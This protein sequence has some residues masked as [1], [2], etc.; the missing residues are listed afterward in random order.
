MNVKTKIDL[1]NEI[2][3]VV[4]MMSLTGKC[5]IAGSLSLKNMLYPND[6]DGLE[7][8]KRDKHML[9][10]FQ[11]VI[12]NL[13]NNNNLFIGDIKCGAIDAYNPLLAVYIKNGI[14]MNYDVNKSKLCI[15]NMFKNKIINNTIYSKT[16]ALLNQLNIKNYFVIVGMYKDYYT[17]RWKIEDIKNGFIKHYE[18]TYSLNDVYD[19][20]IF[21][22]DVIAYLNSKYLEFSMLYTLNFDETDL[23][24]DLSLKMDMLNY[25]YDKNYFKMCKRIYSYLNIT[26][27][28]QQPQYVDFFNSTAGI[29]YNVLHDINVLKY[30]LENQKHI[31]KNNLNNIKIEV[32]FF[33]NKISNIFGLSTILKQDDKIMTLINHF[34]QSK[35]KD[36]LCKILDKITNIL[37]PFLIKLTLSFMR[38]NDINLK[39]IINI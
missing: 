20:G 33:K 32:D 17:L 23:K 4:N 15:E 38:K 13:L 9:S 16:I 30:L 27:N 18:K 21:K 22:L 2:Y 8:I 36:G 26:T 14:I 34:V 25:Y 5:I 12:N 28:K 31:S 1:P 24:Q 35:T 37:N 10:K 3:N 39:Y 6:I 19:T 11:K 7:I 29:I